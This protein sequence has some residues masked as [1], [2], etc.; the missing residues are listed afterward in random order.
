LNHEDAL[1]IPENLYA[2]D[3][4]GG[5][6]LYVF[7]WPALQISARVEGAVP[8]RGGVDADVYVT[9]HRA[10]RSGH[11]R[12]ARF[13][14]SSQSGKDTFIRGLKRR[15]SE[16]DWDEIIEQLC[17]SI[18]KDSQIGH[19]AVPITGTTEVSELASWFVTPII[20]RE[21]VSVIFG[22]GGSGKSFLA[23]LLAILVASG[24]SHA[25]FT[26]TE[27]APVLYLDWEATEYDLEARASMIRKGLGLFHPE[28]NILYKKMSRSLVDDIEEI[29][30]LV[31]EQNTSLL[32]IDSVGAASMGGQ[33]EDKV[34]LPMF[35]LL[36]E[37]K[38]IQK[39]FI[40]HTNK[41]DGSLYGSIFKQN[42]ARHLWEIKKDQRAGE[43]QLTFAMLHRKFNNSGKMP[44]IAITIDFNTPG[45]V[46]FSKPAI[47]DTSLEEFLP[48]ADR[49]V[50]MLRHGAATPVQIAEELEKTEGHIRKELSNGVRSGKF[51]QLQN[52]T[53]KYGLKVQEPPEYKEI[54]DL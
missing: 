11:L 15:E 10:S 54:E 47:A 31:R 43:K 26:I 6:G 41:Q 3:L 53:G 38:G 52:G 34:I 20:E 19:P 37:I 28:T 48:V 12:H 49:I 42:E 33:N 25:G 46:V 30:R 32:I 23:L 18:I 9:S 40:D 2:F 14:L 4:S 45:Q 7:H 51:V 36:R 39:L 1:P 27:P 24:R 16:I 44:D 22:P 21:Q 50:N 8:S 35:N 17:V 13:N 5:Q 29:K